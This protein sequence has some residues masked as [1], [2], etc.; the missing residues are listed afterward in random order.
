MLYDG[1]I[2]RPGVWFAEQV[3]VE[4]ERLFVELSEAGLDVSV[5]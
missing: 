5:A 4:P 1:A 3:V 2:K